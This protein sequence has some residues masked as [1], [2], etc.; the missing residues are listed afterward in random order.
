[1]EIAASLSVGP[2]NVAELLPA[3]PAPA[4][5][6]SPGRTESVAPA[7]A[8]PEPEPVKA[9]VVELVDRPLA[10]RP[11]RPAVKISAVR[12]R[13]PWS[14]PAPRRPSWPVV[15]RVDGLS[16]REIEIAQM[17]ADQ[18]SNKTIGDALAISPRTVS[19]HLTH[20]YRK[21][22]V[23]TRRELADYVHRHGLV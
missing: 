5:S 21:L 14:M 7:P 22:D 3:S 2:A 18:K 15:R 19:T 1:L 16:S 20:I 8:Q 23:A 10:E 11:A 6:N 17:V 4:Q 9:D 12:A 13:R